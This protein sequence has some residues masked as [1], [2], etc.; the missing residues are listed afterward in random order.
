MLNTLAT[1][2]FALDGWAVA[3]TGVVLATDTV[4]VAAALTLRRF[5]SS[6]KKSSRSAESFSTEES[7]PSESQSLPSVGDPK[8]ARTSYL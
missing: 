1:A 6:R 8:S 5:F 2:A 4:T 7:S 3:V